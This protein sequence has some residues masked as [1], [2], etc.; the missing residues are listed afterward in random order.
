MRKSG[1]T[2]WP[3]CWQA[4]MEYH[5]ACPSRSEWL[6]G[7]VLAARFGSLRRPCGCRMWRENLVKLSGYQFSQCGTA[8]NDLPEVRWFD[9]LNVQ[10]LVRLLEVLNHPHK[11][12]PL[13][14]EDERVAFV[15]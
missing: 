13:P 4:R 10:R 5:Q 1:S 9:L 11:H 6:R 15:T 12:P 2:H 7:R 14:G 8:D 3:P